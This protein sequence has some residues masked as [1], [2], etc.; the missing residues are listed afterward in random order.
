MSQETIDKL[1]AADAST[2]AGNY[3]VSNYPPFSF[4]TP[5][6]VDAA[7]QTLDRA[8]TPGVDLGVYVHIPFC[9]KRCHFCYFKVYTDKN[10]KQ[11]RNYIDCVL[12]EMEQ[13]A[14]TPYL[15]GRKPRFIYFGGGTPSYLSADQLK[16]LTDGMKRLFPWDDAQEVTFEAEPGTLNEKKLSR[17]R[18]M[19]VT[20]LSLGIENC[21]DKILEVNNRA[22]RSEEVYKAY[23][24]ARSIEFDQINIDLISGM[25]GETDANWAECVAKTIDMRPDS[26]TIYQMEVPFNTTIYK[27]MREQGKVT[28]P[29]ADWNTKRRWVAEAFEALESAGYAVTS[30][31]T[32]VRDPD[33]IKF[34][35]R[36]AL[37]TGADLLGGGVSSFG[38]LGGTHYQ[39]EANFV[40]YIEKVESSGEQ[41]GSVI[42]RARTMQG[43][44]PLIREFILQMKL[45]HVDVAYFQKK[46]NV[47]VRERFGRQLALL[48]DAQLAT[49]NDTIQL[50]RAGLLQV[51][52][53]LLEFFLPEHKDARYTA[54]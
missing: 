23:D 9:R 31:Y 30:A 42:Y 1:K 34:T 2:E 50:S 40:P 52:R 27:E 38:H 45:G 18:K 10:S 39:N 25:V 46:F 8:A 54:K 4:W 22:H 7:L 12:R 5:D 33:R 32:A 37:W 13:Y 26:V 15:K 53:L 28:A 6:Q 43:E 3:F 49:V 17:I 11:I 29:V 41:P 21:D 51:D 48:Q 44:E 47:D 20:R 16:E 24:F 19:G 14:A 36:D 35:Y